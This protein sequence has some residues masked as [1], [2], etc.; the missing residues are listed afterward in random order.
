MIQNNIIFS[1]S[2]V[3]TNSELLKSL[4]AFSKFCK[5]SKVEFET[6]KFL[7][8]KYSKRRRTINPEAI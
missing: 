8:E 1:Y 7:R 2:S 4:D 6:N 5:E 3:S